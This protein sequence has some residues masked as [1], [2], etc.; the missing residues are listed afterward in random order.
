ML[1][2]CGIRHQEGRTGAADLPKTLARVLLVVQRPVLVMR[3]CPAGRAAHWRCCLL[4]AIKV[5]IVVPCDCWG[6][7]GVG[8]GRRGRERGWAGGRESLCVVSGVAMA[9][10]IAGWKGAAWGV[11]VERGRRLA[12]STHLAAPIL[13][14]PS[15]KG[16]AK[17]CR[18]HR[19]GP[20]P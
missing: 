18:T 5:S 7:M 8:G 1:C 14:H 17:G 6:M 3:K 16:Q 19:Y 2:D 11:S 13:Q 15:S 9:V 10:A 12:A 4:R 20:R